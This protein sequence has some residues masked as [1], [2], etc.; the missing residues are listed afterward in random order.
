MKRGKDKVLAD[1][2]NVL[3]YNSVYAKKML[4]A[5]VGRIEKKGYKTREQVLGDSGMQTVL[6]YFGMYAGNVASWLM[7]TNGAIEEVLDNVRH[8]FANKKKVKP[9]EFTAVDKKKK[10][11]QEVE[12]DFVSV[13]DK[14]KSMLKYS[15]KN[16]MFTLRMEKN[17]YE[18]F[19]LLDSM[20]VP[21][22]NKHLFKE[23]TKFTNFTLVYDDGTVYFRSG[24]VWA[25]NFLPILKDML[26]AHLTD[27]NYLGYR[28]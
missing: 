5:C 25:G 13:E 21:S 28:D 14:L 7:E 10:Q 19:S 26:L 2:Q 1:L 11:G 23:T 12:E 15:K 6:K 9:I 24:M 8:A 27:G 18:L 17:D 20:L 4:Q 16:N 22:V 3:T